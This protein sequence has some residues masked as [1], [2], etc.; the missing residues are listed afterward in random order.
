MPRLIAL[1]L[2]ASCA[3]AVPVEATAHAVEVSEPTVQKDPSALRKASEVTEDG[4]GAAYLP[5]CVADLRLGMPMA[6]VEPLHTMTPADTLLDFR[7]Q[8]EQAFADGPVAN[9]IYYFD[10]DLPGHPLYEVIVE[11]RLPAERDLWLKA[12]L[13]AP[14]VGD[15]WT[16]AGLEW[17]ARAW[18]FD[19]RYV[20]AA[21]M[22]GTEWA[23]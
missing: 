4:P 9:V 8:R 21:G 23:E 7:L 22:P 15:Q 17:P 2:L 6:T 13:G 1:L 19:N 10:G 12:T 3:K 11:W 5:P 20:V 14:N 18:V 16:V